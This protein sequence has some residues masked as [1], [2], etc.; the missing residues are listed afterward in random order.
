VL[1]LNTTEIAGRLRA[2]LRRPIG[3][4]SQHSSGPCGGSLSL[5]LLPDG[6]RHDFEGAWGRAHSV[7]FASAFARF[8][9]VSELAAPFIWS[10]RSLGQPHRS[11]TCATG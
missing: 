11:A 9:P 10:S 8:V 5:T 7:T 3:T 6:V 2:L 4:M 1:A